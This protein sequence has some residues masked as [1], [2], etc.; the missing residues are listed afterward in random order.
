MCGGG[1]GAGHDVAAS[2]VINDHERLRGCAKADSSVVLQC[3][4]GGG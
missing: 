1:G 2:G 4:K 3:M